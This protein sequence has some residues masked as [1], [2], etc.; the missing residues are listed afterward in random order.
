MSKIKFLS[1]ICTAILIS[2]CSSKPPV[3]YSSQPLVSEIK[4]EPNVISKQ[5]ASVLDGLNIGDSRTVNNY[6][7][8]VEAKYLSALGEECMR[9]SINHS[10]VNKRIVCKA[11]LDGWK[12]VPHIV[13]EQSPS[14][15]FETEAQYA[16]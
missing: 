1:T 5:Q 10:N 6:S 12:L 11:P 7:F 15:L 8:V 9:L 14:V 13:V 3:V 4:T 16:Q 2:A